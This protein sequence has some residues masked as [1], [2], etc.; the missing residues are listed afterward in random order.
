MA[1]ERKPPTP[2][3]WSGRTGH[4]LDTAGQRSASG[5]SPG[6][7]DP[8]HPIAGGNPPR[9][10]PTPGAL[11]RRRW[12]RGVF[13]AA[14]LYNIGWGLY[15]AANVAR[16]SELNQLIRDRTGS[17]ITGREPITGLDDFIAQ[18]RSRG[19]DE[20]RKEYEQAVK[21]RGA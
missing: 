7:H 20:I 5:Y 19:G 2:E 11:P 10:V 14:G 17:L 15:S 6:M 3:A 13:V 18:W 21:E 9:S 4:R 16:G 12:H 1:V 8:A